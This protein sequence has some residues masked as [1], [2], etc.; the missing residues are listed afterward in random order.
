VKPKFNDGAEP[1]VIFEKVHEDEIRR[2][3]GEMIA[4][5]FNAIAQAQQEAPD[6]PEEEIIEEP[7]A[8]EEPEIKDW[9]AQAKELGI[10]VYDQELKRPRKKADVLCDIANKS[11]ADNNDCS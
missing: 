4:M 11:L 3:C 9:R 7:E 5:A 8:T 10:P 6:E 1:K 2:I